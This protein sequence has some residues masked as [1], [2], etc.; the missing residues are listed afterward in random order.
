VAADPAGE[1]QVYRGAGA[2]VLWWAWAIFAVAS[3]AV[4]AARY[5]DHASAVTA[6]VILAITGIMYAC[7]LHPRVIAGP[8]GIS[9]DNPL[10]T[11]LIPWPA[12]TRVHLAQTLQVHYAGPLG[13]AGERV[14]HS[15]AVPGSPR[16]HARRELRARSESQRAPAAPSYARGPEPARAATQGSAAEF[17]TRQL[18][19]RLGRER[20]PGEPPRPGPVQV[21]WA[22]GP[23]AAMLVPLLALAVVAA[24]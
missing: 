17:T 7:A 22:W 16:A 12:V 11:H 3:L 8:G 5:H 1:R 23:I 9:V 14:V 20:P 10:R 19:E 18:D 4:I 24:A 15:W 6:T 2:V 21:S 13:G